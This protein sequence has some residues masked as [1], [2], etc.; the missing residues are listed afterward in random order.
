MQII[1]K[2]NVHINVEMHAFDIYPT[3]F[4]LLSL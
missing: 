3:I 4:Q 1:K 2:E